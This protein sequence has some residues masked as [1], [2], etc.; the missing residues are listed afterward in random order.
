[1]LQALALCTRARWPAETTLS[2]KPPHKEHRAAVEPPSQRRLS[3]PGSCEQRQPCTEATRTALESGLPDIRTKAS[4]EQ[5]LR[6]PSHASPKTR[7]QPCSDK[8]T[9]RRRLQ[10]YAK[11]FRP[12]SNSMAPSARGH[13]QGIDGMKVARTIRQ[14][15]SAFRAQPIPPGQMSKLTRLCQLTR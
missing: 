10:A 12:K 5:R 11:G 7:F 13:L 4:M 14:A 1:M 6:I 2:Q 15:I 9:P 8:R 3:H